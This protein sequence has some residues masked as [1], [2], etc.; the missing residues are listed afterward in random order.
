MIKL[1]NL[2]LINLFYNKVNFSGEYGNKQFF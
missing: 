1:Y 2:Y